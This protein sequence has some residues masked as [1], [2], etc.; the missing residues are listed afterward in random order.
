MPILRPD[1]RPLFTR[2]NGQ[3]VTA[4]AREERRDRPRVSSARP[5][6]RRSGMDRRW[7]KAPY[8]GVERRQGERRS[9]RSPSDSSAIAYLFN[10]K[11]DTDHPASHDTD[12]DVDSPNPSKP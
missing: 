12:G 11:S 8:E 5:D 4:P 10:I 3:G 6:Q 2:Q 9:Q 7:I 1:I